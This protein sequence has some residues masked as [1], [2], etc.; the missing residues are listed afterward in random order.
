MV[1]PHKYHPIVIPVNKVEE[2]PKSQEN[3]VED[4]EQKV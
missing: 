1:F 4:E 3:K 2:N